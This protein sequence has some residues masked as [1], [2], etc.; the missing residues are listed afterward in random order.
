MLNFIKQSLL[1]SYFRRIMI[2]LVAL[3][4]I[5]GLGS[6]IFIPWPK[7]PSASYEQSEEKIV[8]SEEKEIS[9]KR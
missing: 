4:M 8:E 6:W 7:D 5:V 9:L 2:L 1:K 3:V